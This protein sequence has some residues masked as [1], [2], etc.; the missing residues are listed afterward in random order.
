MG[1]P[2]LTSL[3]VIKKLASIL[4]GSGGLAEFSSFVAIAAISLEGVAPCLFHVAVPI[5]LIII[6]SRFFAQMGAPFLNLRDH[7]D[8][9]WSF[10][11]FFRDFKG[12]FSYL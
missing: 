1:R 12:C 11:D 10:R 2:S 4:L 5:V 3:S 9:S 6:S 7:L 8:I